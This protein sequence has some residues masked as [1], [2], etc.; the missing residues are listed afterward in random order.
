MT[1]SLIGTVA[2]IL[3]ALVILFF[4]TTLVHLVGNVAQ[5]SY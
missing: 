3:A 1:L 4:G 2:L 5:R